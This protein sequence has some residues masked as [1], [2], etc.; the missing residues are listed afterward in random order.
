MPKTR[1]HCVNVWTGE[2]MRYLSSWNP[3]DKCKMNKGEKEEV[4][5]QIGFN[6]S[7]SKCSGFKNFF[8]RCSRKQRTRSKTRGNSKTRNNRLNWGGRR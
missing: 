5:D 8:G 3:F 4:V 7:E 2:H 6:K 1:K